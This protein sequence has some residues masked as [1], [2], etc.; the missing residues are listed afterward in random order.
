MMST[1][2]GSTTERAG[3]EVLLI[4][5][6]QYLSRR[7][8]ER[9]VADTGNT[10]RALFLFTG[11][12]NIDPP[13]CGRPLDIAVNRSE[14]RLDPV[15]EG[16]L[17]LRNRLA[18]SAGG[19]FAG[20]PTKISP[21]PLPCHM[22]GQRAKAELWLTTSFRCYSFELCCHDWLIFSLHRRPYPP[23]EWSP[24]FLRTT[25]ST[26]T[27][28]PCSRLSRPRST[29]SQSDFRQ[30]VGSSS[31]IALVGSYKVFLSLTDLPCSL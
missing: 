3:Q 25:L 8:L 29:I 23:F 10:Q 17:C 6:R 11:L 15:L 22:M 21:H 1:Q 4:D 5:G 14:H 24:C 20:N 13:D 16:L 28:S 18:V 9:P 31:R 19:R 12:G 2:A 7:A 26:L 30:T 27:A